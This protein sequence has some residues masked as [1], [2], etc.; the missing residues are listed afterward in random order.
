M[1]RQTDSNSRIEPHHSPGDFYLPPHLYPGGYSERVL[2]AATGQA[3][4]H[5]LVYGKPDFRAGRLGHH[6]GTQY[7]AMG[8]QQDL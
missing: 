3:H 6:L 8:I 1:W 5:H 7:S 2:R 4:H